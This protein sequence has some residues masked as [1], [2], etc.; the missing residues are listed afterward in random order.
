MKI[1]KS[2]FKKT[3]LINITLL[4]ISLVTFFVFFELLFRLSLIDFYYYTTNDY[5]P[6]FLSTLK[7]NNSKIIVLGDSFTA[8]G[9]PNILDSILKGGGLKVDVYNLGVGG[10]GPRDYYYR[11]KTYNDLIKPK[12]IVIGL[13]VGNDLFDAYHP[14]PNYPSLLGQTYYFISDHFLVVPYL[15]RLMGQIKFLQDIKN[16]FVSES[17]KTTKNQTFNEINMRPEIIGRYFR[18]AR[19]YPT[20]YQDSI[21]LNKDYSKKQLQLTENYIL[22][23]KGLGEKHNSTIILLIIPPS[24]QVNGKYYD[25]FYDYVGFKNDKQLLLN[26]TNIQDELISFARKNDILFLD[27]LPSFKKYNDYIYY[28]NDMHLNEKGKELTAQLLADKILS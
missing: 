21:L 17:E 18:E 23:I 19:Y 5:N 12:I 22:K 20:M 24:A 10:T 16:F 1:K 6:N 2:F 8:S 4:L 26:L 14:K 15:N 7:Y 9:Y 25:F 27:L 11:L 13:F 3:I 28:F